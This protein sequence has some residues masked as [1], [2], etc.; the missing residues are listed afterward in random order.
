[1]GMGG[2]AADPMVGGGALHHVGAVSHGQRVMLDGGE[3][4]GG[5]EWPRSWCGGYSL[6][7]AIGVASDGR[8]DRVARAE[9]RMT[10]AVMGWQAR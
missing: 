6:L 2:G 9:G 1:M 10:W 8:G 3:G 4:V 7:C 5:W